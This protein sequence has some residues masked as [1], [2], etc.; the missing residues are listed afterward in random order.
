MKKWREEQSTG[1]GRTD[2][3]AEKAFWPGSKD[4]D[5]VHASI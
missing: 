5:R 2:L 4:P 1:F 3:S